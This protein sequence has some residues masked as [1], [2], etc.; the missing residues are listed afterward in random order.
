MTPDDDLEATIAALRRG[1]PVIANVRLLGALI[2]NEQDHAIT[3]L[4]AKI[5]S[6]KI[7]SQADPAVILRRSELL[8]PF[9][10]TPRGQVGNM[11]AY[12]GL[13]R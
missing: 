11:N 12:Y 1:K 9:I 5:D 13:E 3:A 10:Q 2:F 6:C 4:G 7:L 8:T